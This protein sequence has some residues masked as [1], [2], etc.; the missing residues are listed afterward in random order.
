MK[1]P[2][3]IIELGKGHGPGMYDDREYMEAKEDAAGELIDAIKAGDAAATAEAFKVLYDLC[4]EA[5]DEGMGNPNDED[6]Y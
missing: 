6:M 2:A 4:Y 1:G 3:L 5:H